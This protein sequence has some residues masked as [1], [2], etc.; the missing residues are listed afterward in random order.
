MSG[1]AGCPLRYTAALSTSLVLTS[2]GAQATPSVGEFHPAPKVLKRLN[3]L[4][5]RASTLA[6]PRY[7]CQDRRGLGVMGDQR[8]VTL[9][10][11]A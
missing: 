11:I 10:V 8:G 3:R 7:E 9:P 2:T 4:P 6:H 5:Y 1:L